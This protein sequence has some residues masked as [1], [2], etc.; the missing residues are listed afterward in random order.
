MTGKIEEV[1]VITSVRR[2]RWSAQEKAAIARETRASGMS[3]SLV[4]R[5]HGSAPNQLFTCRRLYA[6]GAL[7]AVG[8]C[9]EAVAASKYRALQ[10]QVRSG[11]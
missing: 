8:V 9:E 10:H 7:L 3:V 6:S 5:G 1:E 2:R 4:A 11:C